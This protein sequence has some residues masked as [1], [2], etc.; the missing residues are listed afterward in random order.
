MAV[1]GLAS[2]PPERAA[3]GERTD[4][5]ELPCGVT[6]LGKFD[7]AL[8]EHYRFDASAGDA[9]AIETVDLSGAIGLIFVRLYAP[10]G[11]LVAETCSGQIAHVVPESG[12]YTLDVSDCI[13]EDGDELGP[14][15][16]TL[17]ATSTLLNGAANCGARIPC[18]ADAVSGTFPELTTERP[19]VFGGVVGYTLATS[20]GLVQLTAGEASQEI[21]PLELRIYSPSGELL[22]DSCEATVAVEVGPGLHTLLVN[23][24]TTMSSGSFAL[25]VA[26]PCA[27]ACDL[28]VTRAVKEAGS[29]DVSAIEAAD[30]ETISV[31]VV[32][33]DTAGTFTPAWRL[34]DVA[35]NPVP[36]CDA[37]IAHLPQTLCGPLAASGSPYQLAVGDLDA[38]DVGTYAVGVQRVSA[39]TACEEVSLI[40]NVPVN[41]A[42]HDPLASDLLSF[43]VNDGDVVAV[44]VVSDGPAAPRFAPAWRL[45]DATGAPAGGRCG[46]FSTALPYFRCD[47]LPASGNPYRLEI[48]DEGADAIGSYRALLTLPGARCATCLGDCNGNAAIDIDELVR[49]V[50]AALDSA[51]L[52]GCPAFDGNGDGYVAITELVTAI[53]NAL[54][55]CS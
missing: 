52:L 24:C 51:F 2:L 5:T 47:P 16:V 21:G 6:L 17:S 8:V 41:A 25:Q 49:G 53:H 23:A 12:T 34:L 28:P 55:G 14:Y 48:G 38:A 19:G 22:I 15:T 26:A 46:E 13:L 37:F 3:A 29:V 31:S 7:D 20:G 40:C 30:G 45:L 18:N 44:S 42:L 39:A 1:L 11:A 50:T 36:P 54:H 4:P 9:V 32:G 27:L 35:G 10:S 33:S 43:S